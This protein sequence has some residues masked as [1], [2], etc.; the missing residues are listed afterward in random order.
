VNRMS[1][2]AEML[3]IG[4]TGNTTGVLSSTVWY[5]DSAIHE[6]INEEC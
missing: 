3:S 6:V 5:E 2:L 4:R 1:K